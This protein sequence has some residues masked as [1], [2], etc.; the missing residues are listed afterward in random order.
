[1]HIKRNTS[2]SKIY[3][4]Q[5]YTEINTSLLCDKWL[6]LVYKNQIAI[7]TLWF[8]YTPYG[9]GLWNWMGPKEIKKN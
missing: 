1:M 2:S 3:V 6:F 8:A 9:V 4:L 5:R 7:K